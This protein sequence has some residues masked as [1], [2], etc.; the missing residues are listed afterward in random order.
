MQSGVASS[1]LGLG[2]NFGDVALAGAAAAAEATR[3][4]DLSGDGE[5]VNVQ[6]VASASERQAGEKHK[7]GDASKVAAE[8]GRVR[9]ATMIYYAKKMPVCVCALRQPRGQRLRR[10]RRGAD[11]GG[12]EGRA[13]PA[14]LLSSTRSGQ[15]VRP[16]ARRGARAGCGGNSGVWH[17][18]CGLVTRVSHESDRKRDNFRAKHPLAAPA[19]NECSFRLSHAHNSMR[20]LSQSL[21]ERRPLPSARA[22]PR[23]R[24]AARCRAWSRR[25]APCRRS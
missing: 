1:G 7:E 2:I 10:L 9:G 18:A 8:G 3:A 5:N 11:S 20:P 23:A 17:G 4:M 13:R 14:V 25:P 12:V 21:A 6:D 16:R 19:P 15:R 24:G 22:T